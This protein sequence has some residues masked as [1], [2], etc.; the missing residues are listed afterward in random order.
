MFHYAVL[1]SIPVLW[2]IFLWQKQ[3]THMQDV[4]R[5]LSQ[6]QN[7]QSREYQQSPRHQL[8][9]ESSEHSVLI[10]SLK[11]MV[12]DKEAKIKQLEDEL[13][14]KVIKAIIIVKLKNKKDIKCK[15]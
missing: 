15:S 10:Q 8:S 3:Q 2:L 1:T 4:L 5:Q 12:S 13:S 14:F 7:M 6:Q 11:K 9:S